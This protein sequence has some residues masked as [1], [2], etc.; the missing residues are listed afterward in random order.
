M[1]PFF[2][3]G[4]VAGII[5]LLIVWHINTNLDRLKKKKLAQIAHHKDYINRYQRLYD[6]IPDNY[7]SREIKLLML[8]GL[9]DHLEQW[10]NLDKDNDYANANLKKRLQQKQEAMESTAKPSITNT[11]DSDDAAEIRRRL[12]ELHKFIVLAKKTKKIGKVVA[13][14]ELQLIKH[15]FVET[16]TNTFINLAKAA[17]DQ[18]KDRLAIHY[19]GRALSEYQK[20]NTEGEFNKRMQELQTVI[21]KL[22]GRPTTSKKKPAE[23]GGNELNQAMDELLAEEENSKKVKF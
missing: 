3:A 22:Q 17:I 12:M 14:N 20:S 5:S 18:Q 8:G 10:I 15:L 13:Q 4:I 19:Y 21:K 7:L 11:N 1:S 16:G 9:I 23:K 2:I 6:R